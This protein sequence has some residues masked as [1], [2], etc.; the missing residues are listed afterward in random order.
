MG[1]F[2]RL[3]DVFGRPAAPVAF[4]PRAPRVSVTPLHNLQLTPADV[5][6]PVELSNISLN[7]MGVYR[8]PGSS[9][10]FEGVVAGVL[11]IDSSEFQVA[12]RIRY[13]NDV[14]AGCEFMDRSPGL[15]AAIEAYLRVE[16]LA[17]SLRQ[18]DSAFMKAD[19]RGQVYWFTDGRQNEFFCVADGGGVVAFH[20]TFLGN[21]IEGGRARGVKGGVVN[22]GREDS[23]THKGSAL[24]DMSRALAP[25]M[26]NL[27]HAFIQNV[28]TF[29]Q[30]LRAD[31]EKLLSPGK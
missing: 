28:A 30:A 13:L 8:P 16:I 20:M 21:Y 17:L 10:V 6:V 3:G 27:A 9:W 26:L 23:Q 12:G 19:P 31:V 29:P 2:K 7:G 15:T 22:D 24:V 14:L 18:V 25:E 11:K 1:L 4:R 5:G